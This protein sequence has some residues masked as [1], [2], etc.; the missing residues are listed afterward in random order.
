M[1]PWVPKI[2][3]LEIAISEVKPWLTLHENCKKFLQKCSVQTKCKWI[4]MK[5]NSQ[6]KFLPLQPRKYNHF[7]QLFSL[8]NK[9]ARNNSEKSFEN[10]CSE[11]FYPQNA[12][13]L[14][15]DSFKGVFQEYW[16]NVLNSYSRAYLKALFL[17]IC[18]ILI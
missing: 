5:M 9:K 6:Q 13:L 7:T 16:K 10:S 12:T 4:A 1:K 8:I 17:W 11:E 2:I 3:A 18:L 14:K 15:R